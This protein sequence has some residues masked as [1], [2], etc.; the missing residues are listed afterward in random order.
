M[1]KKRSYKQRSHR[2]KHFG[3]AV[4]TLVLV[5]AVFSL[6][7]ENGHQLGKNSNKFQNQQQEI[8]N[9]KKDVTRPSTTAATNADLLKIQWNGTLD[10]DI[11]H[12]NQN[13]ATFSA[14]ELNEKFPAKAGD[15]LHP[16]DG[17]SL[18]P[19]DAFGRSQQANFIASKTSMDAVTKRPARIPDSVRPSGWY[20]NDHFNGSTWTGGYHQNPKVSLGGTKQAL[21]NKSHIVGYQF[22]GMA[23]MVTE[24][25]TTG[26]RVEN[27]YPGQLVPED[28]IRYALKL[29]PNLTIR[30]QVT[31]IYSGNE[32]VPRG[33]HYMAKSVENNGQ[34]LNF[35]Y[36]VFNVQPGIQINYQTGAATIA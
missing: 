29:H 31:P 3:S 18:S 14:Q 2:P 8:L 24:N 10:G 33:V 1:T 27:A 23:T 25:M 21:W 30:G 13:Q 20:I 9:Q 16:V 28:D 34:A 35:N 32:R 19:L 12:I 11:V 22:F 6:W 5:V 36:W 15:K 26:T 17:L 7:P 4:T